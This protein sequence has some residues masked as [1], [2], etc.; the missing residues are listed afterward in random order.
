MKIL[1]NDELLITDDGVFRYNSEDKCLVK[2]LFCDEDGGVITPKIIIID[3]P[4]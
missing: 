3:D 2:V 4:K 1:R